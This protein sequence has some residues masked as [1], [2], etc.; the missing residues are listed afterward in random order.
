M[1]L[2]QVL[3][4][5]NHA[6]LNDIKK[7]YRRLAMTYH[8][9]KNTSSDAAARF[10]S[11]QEAY[12]TLSNPANKQQYDEYINQPLSFFAEDDIDDVPIDPITGRRNYKYHRS[13]RAVP[14]DGTTRQ[15][16]LS[17]TYTKRF[18]ANYYQNKVLIF[19]M[20]NFF[21]S[22]VLFGFINAFYIHIY[23]IILLPLISWAVMSLVDLYR[24]S[25]VRAGELTSCKI[26]KRRFEEEDSPATYLVFGKFANFNILSMVN[27]DSN[28]FNDS[29]SKGETL[30]F[31]ERFEPTCS[32]YA[33]YCTPMLG[34]CYKITE[35]D[36]RSKTITSDKKGGKEIV[37]CC[38]IGI[39]VAICF[40]SLFDQGSMLPIT[41][42]GCVVTI[43]FTLR[44]SIIS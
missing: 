24:P 42:I 8:P 10:N 3:G 11:I 12:D 44:T 32:K 35:W 18:K 25:V 1:N 23:Q 40:A 17:Y 6:S 31:N 15:A 43:I 36:D 7:A 20:L 5:S 21:L 16:A 33:F 37:L 13:S 38:S 39:L 19:L 14:V 34:F 27:I 26:Y 22:L 28:D 30:L 4:L 41:A 29:N 2:Y 9:D